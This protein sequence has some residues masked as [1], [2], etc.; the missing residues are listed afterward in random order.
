M[1]GAAEPVVTSRNLSQRY[2]KQAAL[3]DV[4]IELRAG[5]LLGL[6]GPDGV[7][8]STLLAILSGAKRVQAGRAG[9]NQVWRSCARRSSGR[10]P[11]CM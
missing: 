1:S 4:S 3:R 11:T 8:K 5:G 10:S 2:G 6:I 9:T 7:C